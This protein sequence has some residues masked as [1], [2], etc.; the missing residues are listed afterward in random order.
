MVQGERRVKALPETWTSGKENRWV[1]R[2]GEGH[3]HNWSLGFFSLFFPFPFVLIISL[4]LCRSIGLFSFFFHREF[5]FFNVAVLDAVLDRWG[6][7]MGNWGEGWTSIC[8]ATSAIAH[9]F[10]HP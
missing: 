9:G 7:G 1:G 5:L 6:E 3:F 4:I 8:F 10:G 2:W